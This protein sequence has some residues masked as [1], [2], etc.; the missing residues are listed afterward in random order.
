LWS[1]KQ[2]PTS[3]SGSYLKRL[4]KTSSSNPYNELEGPYQHTNNGEDASARQLVALGPAT[5]ILA[6]SIALGDKP[7][8]GIQVK[9][10]LSTNY[11]R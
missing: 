10:T 6:D 2:H 9:T 5:N 3:R 11:T 7:Q 4:W 1:R 8:E